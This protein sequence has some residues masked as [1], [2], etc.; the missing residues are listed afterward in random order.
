MDATFH[1]YEPLFNRSQLQGDSSI[2]EA[3]ILSPQSI[4]LFPS[5]MLS[6]T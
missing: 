4:P 6:D 2:L 5:N 3:E 1:D